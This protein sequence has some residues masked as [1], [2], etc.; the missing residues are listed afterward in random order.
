M[1]GQPAHSPRSAALIWRAPNFE[2]NHLNGLSNRAA[3]WAFGYYSLQRRVDYS[4]SLGLK[5]LVRPL[6]ILTHSFFSAP[7][8]LLII[9]LSE[10]SAVFNLSPTLPFER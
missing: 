5:R 4:L 9:V 7:F 10:V 3:D 2:P 1:L 6:R 8:N